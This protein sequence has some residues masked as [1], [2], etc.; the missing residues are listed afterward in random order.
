MGSSAPPRADF[1]LILSFARL[2]AGDVEIRLA[3]MALELEPGSVVEL[4]SGT[5]TISAPV[6]VTGP[7]EA[8]TVVARTPRAGLADGVW[9]IGV[10]SA[11]STAPLA[12]RLLV[13]GDRPVA[14]L[15]GNGD[16]VER[17]PADADEYYEDA[18]SEAEAESE[19]YAGGSEPA[20]IAASAAVTRPDRGSSRW[21]KVRRMFSAALSGRTSR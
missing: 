9:S 8:P 1:D 15:W 13:Q 7:A 18:D 12:A 3:R 11:G 5:T 14:L 10:R 20:A 16:S 4:A 21:A 2:R 19:A 17:E 6:E